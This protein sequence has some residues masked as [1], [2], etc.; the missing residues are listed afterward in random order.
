[1]YAY[2]HTY[3]H[4]HTHSHAHAHA[5][6]H[7]HGLRGKKAD[8]CAHTHT[9]LLVFD[10]IEDMSTMLERFRRDPELVIVRIKNRFDC[11]Y[12]SQLSAGYRDVMV[13][14]SL[15]PPPPSLSSPPT[16][17]PTL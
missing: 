1:M 5:H 3:T 10:V 17:P 6:A 4:T 7:T 12:D 13:S 8:T 15:F 11:Q 9:Q 14:V 2:R 16:H